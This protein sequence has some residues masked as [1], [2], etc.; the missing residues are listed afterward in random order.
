MGTVIG[1]MWRIL[2]AVVAQPGVRDVMS[3]VARRAV[4]TA[5]TQTVRAINQRSS[6]RKTMETF[7]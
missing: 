1:M 6:T 7:R 5:L 2:A 3:Q 4:Q